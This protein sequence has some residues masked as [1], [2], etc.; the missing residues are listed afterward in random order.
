LTDEI[1]S[2]ATSDYYQRHDRTSLSLLAPFEV[3]A[4]YPYKRL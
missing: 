3:M 4:A 2:Q 1:Y